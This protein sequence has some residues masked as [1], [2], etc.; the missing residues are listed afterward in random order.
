MRTNKI[1]KLWRE[2]KPP[3]VAWLSTADTYISEA[4]A[5]TGIDVMVLDM[6]HGMTIGPDRAGLWLQTIS[7]TDSTPMIRVPWNEPVFI[8]WVLDAGAYGVIVPLVNTLEEAEK[9]GRA[10]RYPPEGYRSVGPNRARLYGG[11]DYTQRAN[12]EIICLVMIEDIN[13]I[14]QVEELAGASGIDGFYIGPSD[15]ALSMGLEPTAFRDSPEQAEACQTV[16]DVAKNHGLIAGIHCMSPEEVV[17]R[18]DQ[19]FMFCP[20][21]NDVSA[22]VAT[23]NTA[24]NIVRGAKS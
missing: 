9:A 23:A 21:V 1:K 12:E 10:C 3:T 6:Q 20:C 19:G 7:T 16:L 8:Q 11:A 18:T 15:L 22:V 24:L 14:S 4:I 2:G 17:K 5:N 13:T